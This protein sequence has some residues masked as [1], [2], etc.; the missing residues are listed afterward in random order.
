MIRQSGAD[1]DPAR[2]PA[3][4]RRKSCRV[5]GGANLQAVLSLGPTPLANAFLSPSD[6]AAEPR[7]PLDLHFC[8]DCFLAQLVEVVDPE[9]LF[10]HYVYVSN[11]SETMGRHHDRYTR[12]VVDLLGLVANDLV[13][14]VASND[15]SLLQRFRQQGFRTLGIEPALNI[16]AISRAAGLETISEFFDS[17]AARAIRERYGAAKAVL[18]NNVLAH[19]DEPRDFLA[20]GRT[21]LAKGGLLIIEVP[22]LRDLVDRLEYDT[23]YHEHLCYF[24]VIALMR[25]CDE[26]GLSL[27]GIDRQPVHGGSLRA[28]MAAAARPG[29]HC[30]EARALGGEESIAGLDRLPRYERFAAD[31][32]N[33]RDALRGLLHVLARSGRSLAAYGAPAKSSTLLNYCGID[34]SLIS[35]TVDKNPMKVGLYT[36]GTHIPVRPVAALLEQRPDCTLLLA[37]N[38]ADEIL[39]QQ[40]EYRDRGGRF[41][42]PIPEPGVI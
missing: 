2:R 5:C 13:I 35:F 29:M 40:R 15:G 31:V 22:Y 3:S 25:L 18:A 8:T 42:L 10:R 36:P 20:G 16:A 26:A 4:R 21:L 32:A 6:F 34:A 27:V 41:V 9:V 14:E 11:T 33:N 7:F 30:P 17:S 23:I 38:L 24:S 1:P 37:W 19:V 28:F 39:R 12:T